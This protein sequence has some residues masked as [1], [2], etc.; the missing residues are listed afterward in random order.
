MQEVT[1][2]GENTEYCTWLTACENTWSHSRRKRRKGGSKQPVK[3][4]CTVGSNSDQTLTKSLET[5]N[6][7]SNNVNNVKTAEQAENPSSM[8][9]RPCLF[10]C[11]LSVEKTENGVSVDLTW[12]FGSDK[13]SLNQFCCFLAKCISNSTKD[14]CG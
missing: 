3:R 14:P 5:L 6:N 11:L 8:S 4:I 7:D 2:P 10:H 9:Y 1:C 13:D 12:I